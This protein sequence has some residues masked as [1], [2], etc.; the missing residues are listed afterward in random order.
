M[1][2]YI[3]QNSGSSTRMNLA[4]RLTDTPA[5]SMRMV[6]MMMTTT[7]MMRL[8]MMMTMV[9]TTMVMTDHDDDDAG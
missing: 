9:M 4:S 3:T 2:M 6:M 5:I 1:M 7:M 8:V